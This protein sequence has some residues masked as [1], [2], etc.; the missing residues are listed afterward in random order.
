MILNSFS[1][2]SG[3]VSLTAIIGII[4][5]PS[6][7]TITPGTISSCRP[8]S[9]LNVY[10]TATSDW[11]ARSYNCGGVSVDSSARAGMHKATA[12]RGKGNACNGRAMEFSEGVSGILFHRLG[13][14][15]I[16][17]IIVRHFQ[18]RRQPAAAALD[19]EQNARVFVFH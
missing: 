14:G 16:G 18:H 17:Q 12:A 4:T 13:C 3:Q 19:I 2:E 1:C 9:V 15:R 10:C 11:R 5:K 7:E 8:N 6:A